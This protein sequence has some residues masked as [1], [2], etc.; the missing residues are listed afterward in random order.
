MTIRNTLLAAGLILFCPALHLFHGAT[1]SRADKPPA[2]ME[3][4]K[5]YRVPEAE[6]QDVAI[7]VDAVFGPAADAIGGERIVALAVAENGRYP[8]EVGQDLDFY[9]YDIKR[10][11]AKTGTGP[12]DYEAWCSEFVAWAYRAADSPFTGGSEG[13]WMLKGSYSIRAWF[14][15]NSRFVDKSSPDWTTFVPQ[16]GDYVR[17]DTA[18]GGH[19]GIV[20]YVQ[21]TSLYTVEGNVGNQVRLRAISNWRDPANSIDGIG[22]RKQAIQAPTGLRVRAE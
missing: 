15:A 1:Y 4:V 13:G 10:Y 8:D 9:P 20:R 11:L 2:Q 16:P 6:L 19:S 12:H 22:L 21:G 7:T 17:Y 5:D 14:V 3:D 18:G